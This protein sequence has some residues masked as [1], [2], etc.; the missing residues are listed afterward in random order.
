MTQ[1]KKD[2]L[3][4]IMSKYMA[5]KKIS[6]YRELAKVLGIGY[7]TFLRRMADPETFSLGE[8]NRIVRF[9]GI[10]RDEFAEVWGS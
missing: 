3:I 7:R 9:L 4:G 5:I 6:D 10:P 8:M 2:L 1:K